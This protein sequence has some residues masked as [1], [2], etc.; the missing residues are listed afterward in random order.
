M[1]QSEKVS[2]KFY[3]SRSGEILST[4]F[5]LDPVFYVSWLFIRRRRILISH[6]RVGE[7]TGR[8][9]RR[10][11]KGKKERKEEKSDTAKH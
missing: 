4:S 7:S 6:S 8:V 10:R 3:H 1:Y 2:S 11:K 9:P 5:M